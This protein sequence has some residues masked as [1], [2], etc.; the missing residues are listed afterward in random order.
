M[1]L[2]FEYRVIL[3]Y[4]RYFLRQG[5]VNLYFNQ[6]ILQAC[7]VYEKQCQRY[8]NPCCKFVNQGLFKKLF[9]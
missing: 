2:L 7:D 1:N 4:S 8:P 6:Q 3:N 9:F 5:L